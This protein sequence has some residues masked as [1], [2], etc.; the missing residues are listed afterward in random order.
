MAVIQHDVLHVGV[1]ELALL[2]TAVNTRLGNLYRKRRVPEGQ[3]SNVEE[4]Y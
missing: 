2:S 1:D 3:E 4:Q